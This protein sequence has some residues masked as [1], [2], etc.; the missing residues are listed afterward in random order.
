MAIYDL[1]PVKTSSSTDGNLLTFRLG[2][3]MLNY[4]HSAQE[5]RQGNNTL[6]FI[7][8]ET[9]V[10]YVAS[11]NVRAEFSEAFSESFFIPQEAKDMQN[12]INENLGRE[13]KGEDLT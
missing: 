12:S 4:E 11:V 1:G 6:I 7:D 3:I 2:R 10:K 5:G 9:G 8:R 13:N